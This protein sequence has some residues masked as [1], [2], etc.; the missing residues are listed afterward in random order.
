MSAVLTQHLVS[1]LCPIESVVGGL[2]GVIQLFDRIRLSFDVIIQ[3]NLWGKSGSLKYTF[4]A[5]MHYFLTHIQFHSITQSHQC[6]TLWLPFHHHL[7]YFTYFIGLFSFSFRFW[8]YLD[9]ENPQF[10]RHSSLYLYQ[11][12]ESS[13]HIWSKFT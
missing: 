4:L 5:V 8:N 3:L 2:S 9:D 10:I 7:V 13:L 6:E 1:V 11:S 12:Y